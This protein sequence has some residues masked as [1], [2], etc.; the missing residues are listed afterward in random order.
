MLDVIGSLLTAQDIRVDSYGLDL[1]LL[2]IVQKLCQLTVRKI[3][4]TITTWW[5][6]LRLYCIKFDFGWGSAPD[7]AAWGSLQRAPDPLAG[8]KGVYV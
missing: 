8:F 7:R 6:I 2:F 1:P 4:E 3:L 5:Q